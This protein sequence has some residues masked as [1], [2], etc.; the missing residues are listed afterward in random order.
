M[1]NTSIKL[2]FALLIM[3]AAFFGA[4]FFGTLFMMGYPGI[5]IAL[6]IMYLQIIKKSKR[7]KWL[8]G[9]LIIA[10][11]FLL[12]V[13]LGYA[14]IVF[15]EFSVGSKEI[16]SFI[17]ISIW[18]TVGLIIGTYLFG[19]LLILS[20]LHLSNSL[21]KK[22]IISAWIPSLLSLPVLILLIEI[23]VLTGLLPFLRTF[24]I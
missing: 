2:V 1:K 7:G 20:G 16:Q 3:C 6:I 5:I 11:T 14:A 24:G 10:G 19:S 21:Y 12:S 22:E 23:L 15:T 8:A 18:L 17:I 13:S 9:I 4:S